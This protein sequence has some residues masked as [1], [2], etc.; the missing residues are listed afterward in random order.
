METRLLRS[1]FSMVVLFLVTAGMALGQSTGKLRG[2]VIDK[3]TGEPLVGANV[4]VEGT[5]MGAACD[6][7]GEYIILNVPPGTFSV[8]ATYVGYKTTT[9]RN[10]IVTVGLTTEVNF[11]LE[12]EA[13][14]GPA[15]EIVA[16]VPLINK[17]ATNTINLVRAEQIEQLPVRNVA[18]IFTLA[19]GV[20]SQGG[21]FYV[22]GGR[23][24]E[25]AYYVDG[26]LVNN[27]MGG[28][29][30]LNV[31]N[32]AIEE[33]QTQIGGMTAQYGNAMSAVVSTTTKVGGP[34][35]NFA[36]EL[37]TDELFGG[38]DSRNFLGAYSYGLN[39]YVLTAG[40]PVI[41]GNDKIRFFV[42]GQRV[43]NRTNPTF[44]DGI[45]FPYID[46]TAITSADWRIVDRNDPVNAIET[47]PAGTTGNR[48]YLA[49]LLNATNYSGGRDYGGYNLDLWGLQGNIFMD[50][51]SLN[52]KVGGT[53]STNSN[54]AAFGRGIGIVATRLFDSARFANDQS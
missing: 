4:T 30:Q 13:I 28:Q 21:N 10:K 31:I 2:Q 47:L 44:L 43:F 41:P 50:F 3:E 18:N 11:S 5:T 51:G 36:L 23:A 33:V 6:I 19:P 53:Y 40:G 15:I 1:L 22:R 48:T 38:K 29:L 37:I 42:A 46:S 7:N 32:N 14:P 9:I 25:T 45:S 34:A 54:I 52:V 16:E 12:S 24:E 27:P 35:Y 49:N 26:V 39:E 8:K 20:V 17:N